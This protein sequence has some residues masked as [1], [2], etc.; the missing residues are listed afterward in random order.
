M[1]LYPSIYVKLKM[2]LMIELEHYLFILFIELDSKS[3]NK[4]Y[5]HTR[6]D[7]S[8]LSFER[9]LIHRFITRDLDDSNG[10]FAPIHAATCS[11]RLELQIEI[12]LPHFPLQRHS[13]AYTYVCS[14]NHCSTKLPTL[15]AL[16]AKAKRCHW[17][18]GATRLYLIIS[19]IVL[20]TFRTL[21]LRCLCASCH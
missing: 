17:L 10:A 15:A 20:L 2:Q 7:A 5:N 16:V 18:I 19:Y 8:L 21:D 1:Q 14:I 11:C 6:L 13:R 4:R 12:K 9:D 3:H